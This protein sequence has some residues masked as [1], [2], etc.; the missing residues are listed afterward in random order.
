MHAAITVLGQLLNQMTDMNLSVYTRLTGKA[1][2]PISQR[3]CAGTLL[4]SSG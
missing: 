4:M 2:P 3:L 1:L